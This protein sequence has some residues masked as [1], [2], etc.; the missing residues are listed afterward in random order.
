MLLLDSFS[1]F[2]RRY[3]IYLLSLIMV[4][5]FPVLLKSNLTP[6]Y[7]RLAS[8]FILLFSCGIIGTALVNLTHY[9]HIPGE[10]L[11]NIK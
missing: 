6:S 10:I 2:I 8:N 7:F 5:I 11:Y 3:I 4:W 1:L 9:Y